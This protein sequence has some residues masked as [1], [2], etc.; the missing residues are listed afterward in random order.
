LGGVVPE[1]KRE[2]EAAQRTEAFSRVVESTLRF[3]KTSTTFD[4]ALRHVTA[5]WRWGL[6]GYTA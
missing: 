2:L 6:Q 1:T 4:F 3:R 5:V